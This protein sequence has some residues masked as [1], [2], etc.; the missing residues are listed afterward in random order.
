MPA[1]I[2]VTLLDGIVF[3]RSLFHSS[4][5]YRSAV[6]LG[7]GVAVPDEVKLHA[8]EVI[9]EHMMPGRWP[10]ARPPSAKELAATLVVAFPLDE[11]SVKVNC[12]LPDIEPED[13]D[14]DAWSGVVPL[15]MRPG[16]PQPV[17]DH[18]LPSY[19]AE[20]RR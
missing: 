20:W 9:S 7:R 19:V 4:M 17:D 12:G 14:W 11:A 18:P 2:T 16:P 6:V 8:L 1:C 13:A 15:Q 3:A 5:H 10:D